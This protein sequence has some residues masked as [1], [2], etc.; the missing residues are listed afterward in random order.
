M[1]ACGGRNKQCADV[2]GQ[3][4]VKQRARVRESPLHLSC[5]RLLILWSP[6]SWLRGLD[7][8]TSVS[9]SL[10]CLKHQWSGL[11]LGFL[12]CWCPCT[13]ASHTGI[14]FYS[15]VELNTPSLYPPTQGPIASV[16]P[17]P[18]KYERWDFAHP[19][20]VT[21]KLI[22]NDILKYAF[23]RM[24]NKFRTWQQLLQGSL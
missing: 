7:L 23:D 21:H 16:C 20:T 14:G 18:D 22:A 11:E 6:S 19:T 2:R 1:R 10:R 24:H 5:D 17:D 8:C 12:C 9:D 13:H 4:P 3:I 15:R